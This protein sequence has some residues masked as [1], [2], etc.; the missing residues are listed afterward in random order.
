MGNKSANRRTN[1]RKQRNGRHREKRNDMKTKRRENETKRKA[2]EHVPCWCVDRLPGMQRRNPRKYAKHD[3]AGGTQSPVM[4]WS[5][6]GRV[7]CFLD[8]MRHDEWSEGREREWGREE[9][10]EGRGGDKNGDENEERSPRRL[11]GH[12]RLTDARCI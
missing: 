2:A 8:W 11:S 6:A 1:E 12:V 7:R 10:G 4:E 9:G 3:F 5:G